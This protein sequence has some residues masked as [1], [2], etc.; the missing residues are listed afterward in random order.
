MRRRWRT[1]NHFV[2]VSPALPQP[3][4]LNPQ[5]LE[6]L[7]A[8][9]RDGAKIR[10]TVAIATFDGWSIAVF[11]LLSCLCGFNSVTSLLMGFGLG[12]IAF[13]ELR[14]AG[15]LR[16]L[17]PGA[18][19]IM[20]R[21]QLALATLLI[22]YALWSIYGELTGPGAYAAAIASDPEL[23]QMLA[24]IEGLVRHMVILTYV[25]LIGVALLGQGGLAWF[26]FSRLKHLRDYL[27][28]TP[29]W[30]ADMQRAG[31]SL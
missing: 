26:Y 24:P 12:V 16:R 15:Q 13:V 21:N 14:S 6:Q 7:A 17:E 10:R 25:G 3:P 20:G 4:S 11:A 27:Q 8:A 19:R 2:S 28:R 9:H 30:I 22:L 31:P 29:G 5:H 18:L 23:S 1:D